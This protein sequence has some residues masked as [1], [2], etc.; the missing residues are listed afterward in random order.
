[1]KVWELSNHELIKAENDGAH[2]IYH[3]DGRSWK[4]SPTAKQ[5][6]Q[7]YCLAHQVRIERVYDENKAVS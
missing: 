6:V 5:Y 2:K 7:S 4:I 3:S 1:M